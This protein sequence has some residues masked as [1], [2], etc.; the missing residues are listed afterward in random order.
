MSPIAKLAIAQLAKAAPVID[1][2]GLRA[3]L[4]ALASCLLLPT[5]LGAQE[6]PT[7][8][9]PTIEPATTPP[10]ARDETAAVPIQIPPVPVEAVEPEAIEPRAVDTEEIES[11]DLADEPTEGAD[12][13]QTAPVPTPVPAE[14]MPEDLLPPDE[15]ASAAD[16]PGSDPPFD[17]T[18]VDPTLPAPS[19][20]D[21]TSPF[22]TEPDPA[23]G[24]S[25]D[26][27]VPITPAP[28]GLLDKARLDAWLDGLVEA[29]MLTEHL[30]GVVVSV[31]EADQ[32]VS[33][34][35]WGFADLEQRRLASAS[36]TLFRVGSI[37]KVV[38]ATALMQLAERGAVDL[39]QSAG[40][41]LDPLPYSD[42]DAVTLTHLLTHQ[43]GFEDGY[44]GH[45][46][47]MDAASDHTLLPYLGRY[48]P[49]R[50]RLAGE[51]SSYSN[52]GYAVLGAVIAQVAGTS[53]EDHMD[54]LLS[55]FGMLRS[56]FREH[57]GIDRD[58]AMPPELAR[59][60]AEGYRWASWQQLRNEKFWMH[61]GMAPAGSMS[62]TADDM[63]RFMRLHLSHGL[64]DGR[65]LL[66][67]ETLDTMH[68]EL[69]RH[70]EAVGGNAHGFWSRELSGLRTIEHA[71]AVL[72]F[73][74]NMV[75]IPESGVGIFVSTNGNGGRQFVQDLPRLLVEQFL[76][77]RT[78]PPFSAATDLAER[79]ENYIGSYRSTRRNYSKFEAAGN[80]LGGDIEVSYHADK[81]VLVIKSQTGKQA[82][83]ERTP[84][85]F[86]SERDGT[87][88]AFSSIADGPAQRIWPSYGHTLLERIPWYARAELFWGVAGSLLLLS[89]LRVLGVR[90]RK[91]VHG[92]WVEHTAA[93][94]SWFAAAGWIAFAIGLYLIFKQVTASQSD[95]LASYPDLQ[96][97]W[98]LGIGLVAAAIS[99]IALF[100]LPAVMTR[101]QWPVWR[102][103]HYLLFVLAALAALPLLWYWRLLGYHFHGL[104]SAFLPPL[105]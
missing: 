34:R 79:A 100:F 83:R 14:R 38:T 30:P 18:L 69:T 26:D 21:P 84:G 66:Q 33:S 17:P 72:N 85:V 19:L 71:G 9:E 74:S 43:P 92:G 61:R 104:S 58:D 73:H 51:L 28:Q 3:L 95:A 8:P 77:S 50:V 42:G 32:L 36:E 96:A 98:T 29:S 20:S 10:A 99:L 15:S 25:L 75:L 4:L 80:L 89:L 56:T 48:P 44:L 54:G 46:Y 35:G 16:Q 81:G 55:E 91:P 105:L 11:L 97:V 87:T 1:G 41:Y 40:R 6:P 76:A 57:A 70:H 37:S 22:A 86:V 49:A 65:T 101:G 13:L 27:L 63:A 60:L 64:L 78:P 2:R 52:Y 53:F 45:F 90:A 12:A 68:G 39:Q 94:I 5:G 62:S 59:Q 47:A 23:A 31:V 93:T 24:L 103:L 82:W 67:R 102:R 7:E 88:V